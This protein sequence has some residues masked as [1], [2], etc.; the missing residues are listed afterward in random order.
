VNAFALSVVMLF[1]DDARDDPDAGRDRVSRAIF[2]VMRA[3]RG[4]LR[5]VH[6]Q[7]TEKQD[8]DDETVWVDALEIFAV[9][10]ADDAKAAADAG[11]PLLRAA[12]HAAGAS[13]AGWLPNDQVVV[14]GQVLRFME[15]PQDVEE[16]P[17]PPE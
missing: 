1:S 9:V 5:A 6:V 10:E 4:P 8:P 13:T 16:P 7:L 11:L 17:E 2:D 12:L 15:R 14:D 3:E